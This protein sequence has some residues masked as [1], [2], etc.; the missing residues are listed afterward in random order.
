MSV[1]YDGSD[2]VNLTEHGTGCRRPDMGDKLKTE[3]QTP[4]KKVLKR[5]RLVG[6]VTMTHFWATRGRL[7]VCREQ[8]ELEDHSSMMH[9]NFHFAR[10]A[11]LSTEISSSSQFLLSCILLCQF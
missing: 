11:G 7:S 9:G 3:M 8:S 4:G 2:H 5:L 1:I 6:V 10:P